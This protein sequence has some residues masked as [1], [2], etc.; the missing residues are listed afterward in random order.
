MLATVDDGQHP[1]DAGFETRLGE[2]VARPI[3]VQREPRLSYLDDAA[4]LLGAGETAVVLALVLDPELGVGIL[5]GIVELDN[6][7]PAAVLVDG[8]LGG[9]GIELPG[10]LRRVVPDGFILRNFDARHPPT[11][12]LPLESEAPLATE[13]RAPV[14]PR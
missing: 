13:F 4:V 11:A 14:A 6:Q 3:A 1:M 8:Q 5:R 7:L 2:V 10:S 9:H 12:V